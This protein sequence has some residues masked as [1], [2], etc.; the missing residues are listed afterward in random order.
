MTIAATEQ[1][2]GIVR[3]A[4][5]SA[6]PNATFLVFGS[7]ITGTHHPYSD[8][9][10][11]VLQQEPVSLQVFSSLEESLANSDLPFRVDVIDLQRVTEEFRHR[12]LENGIPLSFT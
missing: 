6:L 5:R 2:L 10:I 11:A 8:L 12:I 1:Q 4:L 3:S 9:D 7:R